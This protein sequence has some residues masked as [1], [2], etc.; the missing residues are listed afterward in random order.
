MKKLILSIVM[1]VSLTTF[2]QTNFKWEKIDSIPKTKDQ[3]YSDTK[4]F[5]AEQWNSAKDVI[6]SDD[7]EGGIIVLKGLSQKNLAYAT[8]TYNYT[9]SYIVKFMSKDGKVKIV[10]DNVHCQSMSFNGKEYPNQ[11]IEPFD[12]DVCLDP[13]CGKP[14]SKLGN[15]VVIMMGELRAELQGIVDSYEKYIKTTSTT[16]DGW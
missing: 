15:K 2:G 1:L 7:K 13:N 12:G 14:N 16:K 8:V 9:Y 6:Q 4:V 5:I 10:I 3:I 11:K